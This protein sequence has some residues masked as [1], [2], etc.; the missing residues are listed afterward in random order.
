MFRLSSDQHRSIFVS[1]V[2]IGFFCVATISAQTITT[3]QTGTNNGYYY[4]FWTDGAGS[5]SM[6]LGSGGNYSTQWS[7]CGNFVCG[8]GWNPGAAR[9]ITYSASFNPSGNAYLCVYGW[10]TNPLVEYY[11]VDSWGTW[12]PPGA[13]SV[14]TVTTD[15]GTYDLYRTQRVN[16]PSIIGTATFYQYWSVRT[17]KRAGGTVTTGNHFNAWAGKGWNLGT[18]NYQIVATEGYQSSGNSNVTVGSTSTS[19]LT[20]SPTSLSVGAASGSSPV[21]VTSN[22]SWTVTDNQSWLSVSPTSGSNNGSFNISYTANTSTSSRSGTVTVSGGGIT[23]T[24]AVM[25]SGTGS[26][27]TYTIVVRARGTSGSESIQLKVNRLRDARHLDAGT[28]MANYTPRPRPRPAASRCISRTTPAAAM[29]RWTT[30]RSME[31]PARL[32]VRPPIPRS[33][34]TVNAEAPTASGCTATGISDSGTWSGRLPG[35]MRNGSRCRMISLCRRTIRIPSIT[36]PPS[37]SG[38]RRMISGL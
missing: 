19:S 16:Q 23:R 33:G 18:H 20:V 6:T 12:R 8:K 5:V 38:Y 7:N 30:S 26:S 22:V 31:R 15:G 35:R 34:R 14:G 1:A 28:S 21:S 11:I 32:K 13:T 10:T 37:R 2:L 27:G 9:T 17:S 4:S 24:I 36:R 29:C 3:N 25:Q